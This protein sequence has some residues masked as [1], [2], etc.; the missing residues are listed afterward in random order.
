MLAVAHIATSSALR[1]RTAHRARRRDSE[2][3]PEAIL[4]SA[5]VRILDHGRAICDEFTRRSGRASRI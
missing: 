5:A 1:Q 4:M 2:Q 3:V